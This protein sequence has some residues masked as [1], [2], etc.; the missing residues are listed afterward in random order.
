MSTDISVIGPLDEDLDRAATKVKAIFESE[1]KRFSRFRSE[2]ELNHV[3]RRAGQVT[4]ISPA[5]EKV[6]QAAL[7]AATTADGLFDP[8]LLPELIAA[9]YDRDF[10]LVRKMSRAPGTPTCV[11]G[12]WRDVHLSHGSLRMPRGMALDLGGIA[13]GW[14]ADAAA[15]ATD[16]SW[17]LVDAG[18]DMRLRGLPHEPIP[19]AIEHPF[20]GG[21]PIAHLELTEGALATSTVTKRSW[22]PGLHHLIDPRSGLPSKSSVVQAT[23]WARTCMAAEVSAKSAVIGG[24]DRL[25]LQPTLA[26]L[27]DGQILSSF[28]RKEAAA[29]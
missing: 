24:V 2:S 5:F 18:G 8:T 28:E 15:E 22:G 17:V 9:G 12:R 23:T 1:E 4:E 13:K 25:G 21:L 20:E 11:A 6:L 19:I 26:M 7:D 3:N 14:T 27:D 16:L 29:A 10:P